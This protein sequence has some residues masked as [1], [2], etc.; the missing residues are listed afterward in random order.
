[1]ASEI[2]KNSGSIEHAFER[3]ECFIKKAKKELDV[4]PD[5]VAKTRLLRIADSVVS[6]PF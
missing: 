3:A 4:L 1:M 5:S 6:R 2:I